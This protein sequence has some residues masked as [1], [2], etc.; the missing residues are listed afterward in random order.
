MS[1]WERDFRHVPRCTRSSACIDVQPPA[2]P[3][4]HLTRA[5]LALR[6]SP[7]GRGL[8][9]AL[10]RGCCLSPVFCE[11]LPGPGATATPRPAC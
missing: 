10:A 5:D 2:A 8:G 3:G 9:I 4:D 11:P 1:G 6:A 7:K